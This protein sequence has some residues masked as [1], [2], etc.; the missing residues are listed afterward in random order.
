MLII[1]C[2]IGFI[3]A[4]LIGRIDAPRLRRMLA[5][6]LLILATAFYTIWWT[7]TNISAPDPEDVGMVSWYFVSLLTIG[8]HIL[9]WLGVAVA[10]YIIGKRIR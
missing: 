3:A 2:I 6:S 9:V 5:G 10:G 8:P 4:L 7:F 1:A